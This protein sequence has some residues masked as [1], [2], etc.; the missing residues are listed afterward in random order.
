MTEETITGLES[1]IGMPIGEAIA[2][3]E[4]VGV[5][6]RVWTNGARFTMEVVDTR[7]NLWPNS[8]DVV[9]KARYG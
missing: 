7:V 9:E 8:I 6:Y 3:L 4:D 5:S 2:C 1:F